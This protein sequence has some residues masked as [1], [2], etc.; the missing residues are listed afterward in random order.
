MA[1]LSDKTDEINKKREKAKLDAL[2]DEERRLKEFE[3]ATDNYNKIRDKLWKERV[4]GE[5]TQNEYNKKNVK[6]LKKLNEQYANIRATEGENPDYVSK[7]QEWLDKFVGTKLDIQ[8]EADENLSHG[9]QGRN[10]YTVSGKDFLQE[11]INKIHDGIK[12]IASKLDSEI[13]ALAD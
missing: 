6:E 13:T 11:G 3:K 7:Q 1:S 9:L 4:K 2:N 12:D 5:L 10:I 8:R